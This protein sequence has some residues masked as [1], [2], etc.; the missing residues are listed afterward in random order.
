A[1]AVAVEIDNPVAAGTVTDR[2]RAVP[3]RIHEVTIVGREEYSAN[4]AAVFEG[5][6][7]LASCEIPELCVTVGTARGEGFAVLAECGPVDP[8]GVG[9]F[10]RLRDPPARH[11]PEVDETVVAGDGQHLAVVR[12]R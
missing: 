5:M 11:I 2:Q 9:I 7:G 3:A 8:V 10:E 12:K 6:Q 1:G 4:D